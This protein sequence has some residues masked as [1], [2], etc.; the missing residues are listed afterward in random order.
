M[1]SQMTI[2]VT[3][4]T[5]L[6]G[7]EVCNVFTGLGH[8]VVPMKGSDHI[9]ITVAPQVIDFVRN[10][11][12]DL[13]VHTAAIRDPDVAEADP[14]RAYLVNSA[15]SRHVA[16]A[17]ELA[18][19]PMVHI[20]TDAVYDGE[21]SGCYTEFHSTNPVS[22]YGHSKLAAEREVVATCLRHFILRIPVLFGATGPACSNTLLIAAS[23]LR[24][25]QTI[26]A[27]AEQICNPTYASD[28]AGA[29][30]EIARTEFYG[31]YLVSNSGHT[32]RYTYMKRFAQ[33]INADTS[34]VEPGSIHEKAARR[35]RNTSLD[36]TLLHRTFGIS[37]RPW[38][39]ALEDCVRRLGLA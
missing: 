1:A 10:A 38:E 33:L 6:L 27:A 4:A 8:E 20:S 28:L 16:L 36:C 22:V 11:S 2:V 24:A 19:C 34:L 3:G 29:I 37:L 32:S 39:T 21:I 26:R 15:G 9:D 7:E 35:T 30:A 13:I 12:P 25:G 31:T 5:G 14:A 17:A 23:R 18:G